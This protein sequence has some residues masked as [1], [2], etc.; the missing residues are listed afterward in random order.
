M[1]GGENESR[2]RETN[3]VSAAPI[4]RNPTVALL[5]PSRCVDRRPGDACAAGGEGKGARVR[6]KEGMRMGCRR[7]VLAGI[8]RA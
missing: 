4:S 7:R 5:T 2:R 1:R 3:L 6:V 8:V